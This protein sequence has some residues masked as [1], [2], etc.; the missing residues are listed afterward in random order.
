MTSLKLH[1][2]E[3]E[4]QFDSFHALKQ[5]MDKL[6]ENTFNLTLDARLT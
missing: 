6:W 1:A 3:G 2:P 4:I 5:L